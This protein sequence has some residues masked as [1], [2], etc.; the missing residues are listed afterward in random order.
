MQATP[1]TVRLRVS[2]RAS[3]GQLEAEPPAQWE[4][5]RF[6]CKGPVSGSPGEWPAGRTPRRAAALLAGSARALRTSSPLLKCFSAVSE[7][8]SS[9]ARWLRGMTAV[10]SDGARGHGHGAGDGNP[11]FSTGSHS[12]CRPPHRPEH[13]R[14]SPR[15]AGTLLPCVS[16]GG[17]TPREKNVHAPRL[18]LPES[19]WHLPP[20]PQRLRGPPSQT[21]LGWSPA[22]S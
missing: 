21:L 7:E 12:L 14:V 20:C 19:G 22:S 8:V 2:G 1:S 5:L 17:W 15:S 3:G 16:R 9:G 18:R 13:L 11:G 10:P 4:A 6:L